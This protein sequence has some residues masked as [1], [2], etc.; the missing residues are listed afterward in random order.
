[1]HTIK[2]LHLKTTAGSLEQARGGAASWIFFL[3]DVPANIWGQL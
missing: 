2:P 1:M 3:L